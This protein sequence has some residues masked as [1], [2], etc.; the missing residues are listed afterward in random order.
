ME[1]HHHPQ[2]EHKPKPWKEYLLEG[3]MIFLAVFM[4][5][6]AENIRESITEHKRAAE[7]A[8]SY[9]EDIKKDTTEINRALRL[10]M[11]KITAT[12]SLLLAIHTQSGPGRDTMVAFKGTIASK[13]LPFEPSSGSLEATKASGA[14][15]NFKQK[16]INLMN[17]Y[18]LQARVVIR[19]DDITQKFITEEM[20]PLLL[21]HADFEPFFDVISV[22]KMNHGLMF[23]WD[24]ATWTKTFANL[25]IYN[26]TLTLRSIQEYKKL[27]LVANKVLIEL[28]KEY[29]LE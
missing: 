1:V 29:D 18:D 5:F 24:N 8:Q 7:F 27:H 28:K 10:G 3:L 25:L 21:S 9:Y 4:G 15:R 26:K 2:L 23:D 6:I 11:H 16:M 12:D 14:V 22:G 19:R 17:E 13:V 20:I